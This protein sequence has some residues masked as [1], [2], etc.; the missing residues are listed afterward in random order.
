METNICTAENPYSKEKDS[1]DI[2]WSHPDAEE[3]EED[4]GKGG[5]VADGDYIRYK[6]PHCKLS[7]WVEL[8]N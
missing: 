8:P 5:G 2:R 6:C 4:Y 7:F 1:K 3:V